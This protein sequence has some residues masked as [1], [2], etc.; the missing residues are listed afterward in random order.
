MTEALANYL[1]WLS[2]A[3]YYA[4]KI[5]GEWFVWCAAS[6]HVV[7][8]DDIVILSAKRVIGEEKSK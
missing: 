8:F 5:R 7:E 4:K 1:V 2:G 6:D 3:G